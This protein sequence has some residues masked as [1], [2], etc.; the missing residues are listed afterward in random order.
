[1][2]NVCSTCC[3]VRH[4]YNVFICVCFHPILTANHFICVVC[5]TVGNTNHNVLELCIMFSFAGVPALSSNVTLEV[6]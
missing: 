6:G 5:F 2:C 4:V 3:G 1:M